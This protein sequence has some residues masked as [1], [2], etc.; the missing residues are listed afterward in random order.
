MQGK[1]SV[2]VVL[3]FQSADG[4]LVSAKL[5]CCSHCLLCTSLFHCC[6]VS[7]VFL[8]LSRLF[9]T[10]PYFFLLLFLNYHTVLNCFHTVQTIFSPSQLFSHCPVYF[11][12]V[13]NMFSLSRIFCHE[14][15]ITVP[16]F[17]NY[18]TTVFFP[19]ILLQ[20]ELLIQF[21][22]QF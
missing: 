21:S 20:S 17:A 4:R 12:L 19:A 6:C 8:T 9:L 5:K 3:L 16:N 15:F 14:Y 13:T 22:H 10:V 18:P 2:P 1:Y 7:Q 11:I